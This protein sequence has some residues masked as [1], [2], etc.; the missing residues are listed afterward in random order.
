MRLDGYVGKPIPDLP[1]PPEG[2]EAGRVAAYWESRGY[3]TYIDKSGC[4]W[5]V[6][7]Y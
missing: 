6:K 3:N 1:E 5:Y 4:Y 7:V 2:A